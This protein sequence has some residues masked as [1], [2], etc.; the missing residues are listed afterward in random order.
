[1][2][3]RDAKFEDHWRHVFSKSYP[4]KF[5]E[6]AYKNL[7]CL[8][9]GK[10]TF[11]A[12]ISAI[13]GGN[14]VGKS[15][16]VAS[17]AQLLANDPD[18]PQNEYWLRLQGS[19]IEGRAFRGGAEIPLKVEDSGSGTRVRMG[20]DFGGEYRILE[21][22]VIASAV[23]SQI[24]NDQNFGDLLEP[25]TPLSLNKDELKIA[26]HLVHKNYSAIDIYEISDYGGLDAFPYFVATS[27]GVTYG[28]EHMG[29]GELAVLLTYWTLRDMSPQSVLILEEPETHVSPMSQDSLMNIVAK[30][31]DE[32]AMW[33]IVTTQSPTVIRRIPREH[34]HLLVRSDGRTLY[35]P[36]PSKLEVS[37]LL[38]GGVAYTGLLLVEDEGGKRLL[39]EI[40]EKFEP[41][42]LRQFSVIIAGSDSSITTILRAMPESAHWLTIFGAYDGDARERID[43]T[44]HNW[45]FGFLP[46]A[47]APEVALI[48]MANETAGIAKELAT[49]LETT[50]ERVAAALAHAAGADHHD[51]FGRLANFLNLE[52]PRIYRSFVR[53][54]LNVEANAVAARTF[55]EEIRAAAKGK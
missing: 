45:P 24:Y 1:M 21:P 40:L 3:L 18:Q 44:R 30:F 15:T 53:L 49:D 35:S 12:G 20:N 19:S 23:L 25:L 50:E 41:D 46:G 17:I 11:S 37:I 43:G 28:S 8:A 51:Y 4:T 6:I 5:S 10:I 16:L 48:D 26:S 54:W 29:R 34:L 42:L 55:V 13:V 9:D 38:G 36:N 32:R 22:A 14:G 2:S 31:S 52:A 47:E 7:Y 39:T 27:A 33:V